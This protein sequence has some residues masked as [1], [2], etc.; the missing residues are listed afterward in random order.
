[1]ITHSVGFLYN[2]DAFNR[3]ALLAHG[4]FVI[5]QCIFYLFWIC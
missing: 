4:F 5:Y 3:V 1:M 2:T